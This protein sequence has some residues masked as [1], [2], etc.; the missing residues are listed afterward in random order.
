VFD[1]NA[2]IA[3]AGDLEQ[4]QGGV[5]RTVR[6]AAYQA[7]IANDLAALHA[8]DGLEQRRQLSMLDDFLQALHEMIR[9]WI[10]VF[11]LRTIF[12]DR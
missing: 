1:F 3:G 4:I 5:Q 7:F 6:R 11:I 8:D 12:G 9:C 2:Q 10:R